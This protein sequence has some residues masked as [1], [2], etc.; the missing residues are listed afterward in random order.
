MK[1]QK[2]NLWKWSNVLLTT[3]LAWLGLACSDGHEEAAMYG[4]PYAYFEIKGQVLDQ[5]KRPVAHAQIEITDLDTPYPWLTSD[6]IYTDTEGLFSWQKG[7]FPNLR[8]QLITT[9]PDGDKYAGAYAADTSVIVFKREEM[10]GAQGWYEG[11]GVRD[12]TLTLKNYIDTHTSP[13]MLYT[14]HGM[15]TDTEGYP[16]AGIL[17]STLPGYVPSNGD[18][19]YAAITNEWGK[20]QFTLDKATVAEHTFYASLADFWWNRE[21]YQGDSVVVDFQEIPLTGG[22][23]MLIGRGGKEINFQLK[24]ND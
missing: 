19:S 17:I 5:Q 15:V 24:K 2:K 10:T 18:K 23:G 1:K 21:A 8:Y 7:G 12:T 14:F 11:R 22:E 3:L 9:G 4:T 16:L 6:T 13:Y 20:Y